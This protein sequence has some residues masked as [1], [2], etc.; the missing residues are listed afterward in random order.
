MEAKSKGTGH[1]RNVQSV[2]NTQGQIRTIL[3]QTDAANTS[4]TIPGKR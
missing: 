2:C 4:K 1:Y 3:A